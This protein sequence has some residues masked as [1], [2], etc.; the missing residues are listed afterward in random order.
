MGGVWSCGKP[1]GLGFSQAPPRARLD[2]V[3]SKGTRVEGK[4]PDE[5]PWRR[6]RSGV[7]P[8]CPQG[9]TRQGPSPQDPASPTTAGSSPGPQDGCPK[10]APQPHAQSS[11]RASPHPR[12]GRHTWPAAAG[13]Q[14]RTCSWLPG[15]S[16]WQGLQGPSGWW[17]DYPPDAHAVPWRPGWGPQHWAPTKHLSV[18]SSTSEASLL[19]TP[20]FHGNC[21]FPSQFPHDT[22][23]AWPGTA[24]TIV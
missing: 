2:A 6:P 1:E 24:Q 23:G 14:I 18:A 21:F 11:Y 3:W 12:E 20:C 10:E 13:L 16:T 5:S 19:N 9:P 22:S 15:P 7:P 17:V 8:R 4:R